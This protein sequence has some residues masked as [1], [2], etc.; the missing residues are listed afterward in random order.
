MEGPLFFHTK[1]VAPVGPGQV[2]TVAWLHDSQNLI[3]S[4]SL[5]NQTRVLFSSSPLGLAP[6]DN[7]EP[8]LL[9]QPD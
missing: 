6:W 7:F 5:S 4:R 9:L 8:C 3:E 2:S 1:P